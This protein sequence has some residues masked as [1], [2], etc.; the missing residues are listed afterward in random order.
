MNPVL[1]NQDEMDAYYQSEPTHPRAAGVMWPALVERRLNA[2]F[3]TAVCRDQ[4]VF[5]ELFQPSGALGNYATKVRLAYLLGWIGPEFYRDLVTLAKIRNRF[6]HE[7]TAKDF[8]DQKIQ[9]WL[10]N[11]KTYK[12]IPKQ[13]EEAKKH[14]ETRPERKQET[15]FDKDKLV[16]EILADAL[17]DP[18][19]AFRISIDGM[20]WNLDLIRKALEARLKELA[21]P[22][23][24]DAPAQPT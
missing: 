10:N 8:S 11:L 2:L 1:K 6:A 9:A 16:V 12:A 3:E 14:L 24:R 23:S 7:I 5:N 18:Q 22:T 20:L 17:T 21:G 13:L 19:L 4:E 15:G